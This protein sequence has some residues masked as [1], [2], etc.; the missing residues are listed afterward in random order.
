MIV[1]NISGNVKNINTLKK[2]THWGNF[3]KEKFPD[4]SVNLSFLGSKTTH[5]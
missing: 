5:V 2:G 3:S 4:I 1:G